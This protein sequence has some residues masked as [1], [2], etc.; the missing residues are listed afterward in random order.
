MST[1]SFRG[2]GDAD[3]VGSAGSTNNTRNARQRLPAST[4]AA[5]GLNAPRPTKSMSNTQQGE[6]TPSVAKHITFL[7]PVSGNTAV[8]LAQEQKKKKTGRKKRGAYAQFM[9]EAFKTRRTA[10]EK[11]EEQRNKI[12]QNKFVV[13][14]QTDVL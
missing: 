7:T 13:S 5:S 4:P 1:R 2:A 10:T 14:K 8:P 11:Q 3:S 6:F 9:R 12:M